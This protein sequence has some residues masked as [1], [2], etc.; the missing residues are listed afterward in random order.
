MSEAPERIWISGN[1]TWDTPHTDDVDATGYVRADIFDA[2][3]AE[4]ER[5]RGF[6][7]ALSRDCRTAA[8]DKLMSH[9]DFI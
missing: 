2:L 9:D 4:N 5:L 1:R 3:Q 8:L 7:F 6:I